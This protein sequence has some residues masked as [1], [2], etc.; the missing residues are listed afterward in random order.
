MPY[1]GDKILQSHIKENPRGPSPE[2][3]IPRSLYHL[4][5]RGNARTDI[6]EDNLDCEKFLDILASVVR[7]NRWICHSY[8]LMVN[9]YHL[10]VETPEGN[11]CRGMRQLNG[12]YT[13]AFNRRHGRVGH[14][15]QGRYKSILVEKERRREKN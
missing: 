13:Q 5:S 15:F 1:S 8:C 14:L 2:N 12:V 4:T 6:F 10:L 11:L 7:Q 9:H 3:R